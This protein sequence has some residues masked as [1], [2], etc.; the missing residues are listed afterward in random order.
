VGGESEER[1]TVGR[2]GKARPR[3]EFKAFLYREKETGER[4]GNK[5][6]NRGL[7][8]GNEIGEHVVGLN[9]IW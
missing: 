4:G 3:S 2:C 5:N 7:K 9:R 8:R 6:L 1:R